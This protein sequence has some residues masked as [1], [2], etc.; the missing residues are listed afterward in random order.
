[1]SI[2]D[3][4]DVAFIAT[5]IVAAVTKTGVFFYDTDGSIRSIIHS[6]NSLPK[7]DKICSVGDRGTFDGPWVNDGD[8]V[9]F[10]VDCSC[11]AGTTCTDF[12]LLESGQYTL[13]H[14]DRVFSHLFWSVIP[15]PQPKGER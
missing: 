8:V 2:N 12:N 15:F 14:L 11:A 13:N 7:G 4:G 1:M 5:Y 9:A 3:D 6:D 10:V